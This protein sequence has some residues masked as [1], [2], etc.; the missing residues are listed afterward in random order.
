MDLGENSFNLPA[1]LARFINMSSG[2]VTMIGLMDN[3]A[4]TQEALAKAIAAATADPRE[5]V[6]Q[7]LYLMAYYGALGIATCLTVHQLVLY[8]I[9]V[10]AE[11]PLQQE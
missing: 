5:A 7:R 4:E 11:N 9:I 3:I 6:K 10:E 8:F 1:K 2:L